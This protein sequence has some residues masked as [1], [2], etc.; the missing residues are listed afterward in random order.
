MS[1][2][3]NS[4][5]SELSLD[6]SIAARYCALEPLGQGGDG[7]VYAAEDARSRERVVLKVY[8]LGRAWSGAKAWATEV[9]TLEQLNHPAVPRHVAHEQLSDGRLLLVRSFAPGRT[10]KEGIDAGKRT[11]TEQV[12]ALTE[13]LLDALVHLQS[14]NP[15]VIH[16]DIKPSNIVV[17]DDGVARL[18]DFASVRPTLRRSDVS[19][20]GAGTLG[21]A[22]PEQMTGRV[23]VN[24]DLY[25]LGASLV[26]LLSHVHPSDVPTRGL[27]LDYAPLIQA[28]PW[29]V[30]WLGRLLQPDPELRFRDA[31][32]AQQAFRSRMNDT[33]RLAAPAPTQLTQ[34]GPTP[35]ARSTI[36]VERTNMGLRISIPGVGFFGRGSRGEAIFWLF[37]TVHIT[38]LSVGFGLGGKLLPLLLLLPF[39]GVSFYVA[40]RVLF[41]MFGRTDIELTPAQVTVRRHLGRWIRRL[42]APLS[43]WAGVAVREM[44][45]RNHTWTRCVVAV[46]VDEVPFGDKLSR[47]EQDWVVGT[48]NGSAG[49]LREALG[50]PPT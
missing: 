22:A 36:A 25:S 2:A 5:H 35:P 24:T 3:T 9:R 29:F 1:H 33:S 40:G 19:G 48:L 14:L 31:E 39:W 27:M 37:W 38:F 32:Q 44:R 13:Q 23:G 15:P 18:I 16:G 8:S 46:G 6:P 42:E 45:S 4:L 28:E 7:V 49:A 47:V 26:H 43:D 30:S 41:A 17:D 20:L 12:L 21:Y 11:T 34:V 50:L 10:L